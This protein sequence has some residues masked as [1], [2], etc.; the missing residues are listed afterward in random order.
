MKL[1]K[2]L[3]VTHKKR[4]EDLSIEM[5]DVRARVLE[6]GSIYFTVGLTTGIIINQSELKAVLEVLNELVYQL[7]IK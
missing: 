7:D 5:D 4:A 2:N 1:T 6:S 3:T